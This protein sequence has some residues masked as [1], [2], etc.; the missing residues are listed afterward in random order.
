MI[1]NLIAKVIQMSLA[2]LFLQLPAGPRILNYE[3]VK[4]RYHL[5][6]GIRGYIRTLSR[7]KKQVKF[8]FVM[9]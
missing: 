3:R 4:T 7:W 1:L 5:T 2:S 8:S 9:G 6:R